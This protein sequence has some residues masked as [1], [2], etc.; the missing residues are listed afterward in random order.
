[1]MALLYATL[2]AYKSFSHGPF[3]YLGRYRMAIEDEDSGDRRDRRPMIR[4]TALL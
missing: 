3:D 1:M 2:T 4:L